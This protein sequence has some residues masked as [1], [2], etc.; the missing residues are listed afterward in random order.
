MTCACGAPM[1]RRG[2]KF[3]NTFW[4]GCTTWPKC[5]ITAQ[6]HP[7]GSLM[8]YPASKEVQ[9]LRRTAHDL[10]VQVFGKW[11][12]RGSKARMYA[13]LSHRTKEGH[14]GKATKEELELVIK[15]LEQELYVSK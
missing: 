8:S 15:L 10:M 14:I 1:I 11:E 2:S 4:W 6:E 12:D 3:K 13:W 5:N 9:Q 7:D